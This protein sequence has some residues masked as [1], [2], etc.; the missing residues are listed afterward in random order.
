LTLTVNATGG[1]T[2]TALRL[3]NGI[4]GVWDTTAPNAFWLLGVAA[5]LDGALLN[6]TTTMAVNVAVPD[7]GSLVL[8]GSDYNAGQGF[9]SGRILTVTAT[10]SDGTSAARSVVAP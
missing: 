8:F 3:Q 2:V 10:F 7:G 4:G 9:G 5:S 1:R 6:S